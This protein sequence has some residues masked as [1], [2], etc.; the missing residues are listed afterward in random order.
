L[1]AN[2]SQSSIPTQLNPAYRYL[3]VDVASRPSALLV[4]GYVDPHPLGDIEVWY[5]SQREVIKTQAGR[6]IATSGLELDWRQV[7][8]PVAPL[9]WAKAPH[10]STYQR[11]RDVMPGYRMGLQEA[12]QVVA[13]QPPPEML[14]PSLPAGVNWYRETADAPSMTHSLPNALPPA[15]FAVK[16]SASSAAEVV[17]SYQCLSPTL[18]LRLQRWPVVGAH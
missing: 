6:V 16:T 11:V 15:W 10:S 9:P 4:L 17:A 1:L 3:R 13:L 14:P 8:F 12:V 5:S 18:C 7:S 2:T